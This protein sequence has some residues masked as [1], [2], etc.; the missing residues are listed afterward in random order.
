MKSQNDFIASLT[1]VYLQLTVRGH[2]RSTPL[3]QLCT[4]PNDAASVGNISGTPAVGYFS[5]PLSHFL[6]VFKNLKSS[7]LKGRLYFWKLPG[8]IWSQI[9][10]IG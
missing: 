2:L 7:S 3:E 1:P 8:I 6:D 4:W 9:R 10:G 5:V